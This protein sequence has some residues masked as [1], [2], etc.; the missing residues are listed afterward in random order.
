MDY[1]IVFITKSICSFISDKETGKCK[2][3]KY[4][5]FAGNRNQSQSKSTSR[6]DWEQGNYALTVYEFYV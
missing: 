1:N 3:S 2:I 6:G 5:H 4:C